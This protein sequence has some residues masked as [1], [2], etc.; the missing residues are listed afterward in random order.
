MSENGSFQNLLTPPTFHGNYS[1]YNR[2]IRETLKLNFIYY[3]GL[4]VYIQG[5]FRTNKGNF[6]RSKRTKTLNFKEFLVDFWSKFLETVTMV[7]EE[8]IKE[9]TVIYLD[10]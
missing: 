10:L 2:F 3:K 4:Y 9:T 8:C 7:T 6:N 5:I 1:Y